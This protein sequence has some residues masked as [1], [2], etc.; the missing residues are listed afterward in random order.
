MK[1]QSIKVIS[2][3]IF[4]SSLTLVPIFTADN[5][6]NLITITYPETIQ[7][8]SKGEALINIDLKIPLG[9]FIFL[10]NA[11]NPNN[12]IIEF[13]LAENSGIEIK[14]IT[15]P[16][17]RE[18][19][20]DTILSSKGTFQLWIIDKNGLKP[21]TTINLPLYIS[22]QLAS[23]KT[24]FAPYT[25]QKT[26]SVKVEGNPEPIKTAQPATPVPTAIPTPTIT[27]TPI[28]TSV[29]TPKPTLAPTIM[30][31]AT[32]S[33]APISQ[34]AEIQWIHDYKIGLAAA[35]KENKKMFLYFTSLGKCEICRWMEENTLMNPDV[36]S[37]IT[38]DFI[39]VKI[40]DKI[41]NRE[42]PDAKMFTLNAYPTI[43]IANTKSVALYNKWMRITPA[44]LI[45]GIKQYAKT[46]SALP[47]EIP[48]P[49]PTN[50][51]QEPKADLQTFYQ[52]IQAALK[53]KSDIIHFFLKDGFS[54]EYRY[55]SGKMSP[56]DPKKIS[57]SNWTGLSP[58]ADKIVAALNWGSDLGHL[59]LND[60]TYL[61]INIK[62]KTVD[63]GYP[64]EIS[65]S[66]WPGLGVY[67]KNI[68][69]AVQAKPGIIYFFLSTGEYIQYNMKNNKIEKGFPKPINDDT[70]PGLTTYYNKI[71]A[72]TNIDNA[73][74]HFF[75][76][77]GVV[78]RYNLSQNKIE[79]E[80]K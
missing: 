22:F 33:I 55:N 34:N 45:N 58:Y 37:L 76:D 79:K 53:D 27:P 36:V 4:L 63:P 72:V 43:I 23:T 9:Y 50:T 1:I 59:F 49:V 28:P 35:I 54:V 25:I 8:Q 51:I 67:K 78:I 74:I 13:K 44:E 31:T 7:L 10:K 71:I 77:D 39:A 73:F 20:K 29:P 26:L 21:N 2:V 30:P 41:D 40:A 6:A 47:T 42:N 64:K 80:I 12:K 61:R 68:M 70:W 14:S 18:Y 19:L 62:T 5:P 11:G 17:G 57:D 15:V 46:D 38:S 75:L 69:G 66:N 48:K 3:I 24:I 60:G 16:N 56:G 52:N 65:N 32:P